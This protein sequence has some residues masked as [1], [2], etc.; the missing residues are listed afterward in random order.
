MGRIGGIVA[1]V[2]ALAALGVG[3]W[4]YFVNRIDERAAGA[5]PEST[6]TAEVTTPAPER[7]YP[8]PDT[9]DDVG[10]GRE[11]VAD[12]ATEPAEEAQPPPLPPLEE[13]DDTVRSV[14]RSLLGAGAIEDWLVDERIVERLVV[15]I[16]SLDGPAI[17]MRFWPLRHIEGLP[18]VNREQG[19]SR[20][21][22]ANV[23]RYRVPV[24]ILEAADPHAV[25]QAYFR[26]YPLFQ[27]AYDGLGYSHAHFNDRL[28]EIVDHLLDAPVVESDFRVK[29]PKVL[30]EFADPELEAESWGRKLLM[31][32]GP[33]NAE[34]VKRWLR[35]VRVHLISG[36]TDQ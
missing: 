24:S 25:A 22:P 26:H 20:W 18:V 8:I 34:R 30:Y 35:R 33:E 1:I 28:V 15:T 12:E 17:P 36:R 7:K 31:R 29:Q 19:V 27:K 11:D 32:M 10:T 16:N 14:L 23:A 5:G 2:L 21:S 6:E 9:R 3:A 4:W 13:S